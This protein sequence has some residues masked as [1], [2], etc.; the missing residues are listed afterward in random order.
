MARATGAATSGAASAQFIASGEGYARFVVGES[1]VARAVGL[2]KA[3]L[4]TVASLNFGFQLSAASGVSI[5]EGGVT[6]AVLGPYGS[7]DEFKV[8]VEGTAV[9]YRQ[10][11][12]LVYTSL[13]A[14]VDSS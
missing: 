10:N 12:A 1:G 2:A 3:P 9:V 4:N 11:N 7:G 13:L 6:K 5:V 8:G 14:P